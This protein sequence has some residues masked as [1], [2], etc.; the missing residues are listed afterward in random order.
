MTPQ[1]RWLIRELVKKYSEY[2][3]TESLIAFVA[4]TNGMLAAGKTLLQSIETGDSPSID[5]L[6]RDC[7]QYNV[8]FNSFIEEINRLIAIFDP[9]RDKEDYFTTLGISP[10]AGRDEIRQAYRALSLQYHPDT[11]SPQN[12]DKPEK[13]IAI[14]KA[15]HALLTAQST[16]EGDENSTPSKQWQENRTR[17]FSS[18]QKK[19]LFMWASAAL[20]VLAVVSTIASINIKN[21]AMLAGLQ[22]GRTVPTVSTTPATNT[23]PKSAQPE[24]VTGN[25]PELQRAVEQTKQPL[26]EPVTIIDNAR[27]PDT[28]KIPVIKETA[29]P[30]PA[31]KPPAIKPSVVHLTQQHLKSKSTQTVTSMHPPAVT[32]PVEKR[33][34]LSPFPLRIPKPR[35]LSQR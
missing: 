17:K 29:A 19:K 13:F 24:P 2:V 5:W 18:G 21:R 4:D 23:V 14:N 8:V 28:Q 9:S 34:K 27:L 31:R 25:S 33:Q 35:L 6:F 22:R 7:L 10:G 11:A 32:L 26:P 16:E 20:V 1:Q 12:R 3:G 30:L 15:Y